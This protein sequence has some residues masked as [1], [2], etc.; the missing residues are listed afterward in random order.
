VIDLLPCPF[1]GQKPDSTASV[2][3][4]MN[5]SGKYGWVECC[6]NGPEVRIGLKNADEWTTE[7]AV[8]WNKRVDPPDT[9]FVFYLKEAA[10]FFFNVIGWLC[11]IFVAWLGINVLA[12]LHAEAKTL[13]GWPSESRQQCL[14]VKRFTEE[15]IWLKESGKPLQAVLDDYD[16]M[17]ERYNWSEDDIRQVKKQIV[18]VW[19]MNSGVYTP[20][21]WI[22]RICMRES[23]SEGFLIPHAPFMV[24]P[25]DERV[26]VVSIADFFR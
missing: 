23:Y 17:L 2:T 13:R 22:F 4:Q 1:C 24:N 26:V 21:A 20:G 3:F 25:A 7:A 10:K 19:A 16:A 11:V 8:A 14:E 5:G 6:C 15:V 12:T 18:F 9:Q